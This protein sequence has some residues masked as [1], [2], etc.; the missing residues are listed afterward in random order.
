[1]A[2]YPET[3]NADPS[4]DIE[5]DAEGRAFSLRTIT[6]PTCEQDDTELV[7]LRGGRYH[8][9]RLGI[10]SRI[11]RCKS[12]GLLYPNPFPIPLDPLQL[13]GDPDVY[14]ANHNPEQK[15]Q[16]NRN[17]IRSAR[18]RRGGI[19]ASVLDVGSGRGELLEAARL[20][21]VAE[22][23]GLEFSTAMIEEARRRYG[24]CVL[25]R[26]IEQLADESRTSFD[27]VFLNAV[28]EHV[29]D[30]N[31]MIQAARRLTRPGSVLYLDLPNEPHL[32]SRLGNALNRV[33]GSQGVLNLSPTFRPYHVFGFNPRALER[34]LN[35]HDFV[36]RSMRIHA[37]PRVRSRNSLKDR[38]AA[39]IAQQVMRLANVTRTASNLFVWA[40]R[41]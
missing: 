15:V 12:C 41:V 22:V 3:D 27:A 28:L 33:R 34:L 29:Y 24:A 19:L 23:V 36:I 39:L 30:P 21:N 6:C 1:M 20:E 9:Y 2:T 11:V 4:K 8:R 17:L 13:Y 25:N 31:T 37:N 18:E 7:G 10:V 16:T 38:A 5:Q 14:F 35:K 32:L 40:E 26:T